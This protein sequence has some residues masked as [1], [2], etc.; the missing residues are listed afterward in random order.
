MM[1]SLGAG[2]LRSPADGCVL[3][4]HP[5]LQH[6]HQLAQALHQRK[7]LKAFWSG[8]PVVDREEPMPWWMPSSYRQRIRRVDIPAS[9]REHPTRFQ[10]ALRATIRF[11]NNTQRGD[12]IHRIFHWFDKWAAGQVAALQP[13][14]VVAY[15]NAAYHTFIAAKAAGALCI[16]DAAAFHHRTVSQQVKS[17]QTPYTAE[18]NRRKDEEIRMAD[19][20]LTCSPLAADSYAANGIDRRRLKPLLLGADPLPALAARTGSARTVPRFIF[21]GPLSRRKAVDLMLTAFQRLHD[22]GVGCELYCVGGVAEPELL[23]AV[24]KTPNAKYFASMPQH[25]LFRLIADADCLVLPSRSDSFGMVVAEAMSCGT[26]ALVST[27]TGAKAIVE[28]FPGSGWIVEPDAAALC[29]QLRRLIENPALLT[30]AR[31]QALEASREFSWERYRKRAG[32][33][34]EE[35]LR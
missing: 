15:E 12:R 30:E 22:E 33:V 35:F 32:S 16:L 27:Q 28:A 23:E 1:T 26:P 8:V 3:V 17:G 10:L 7:L 14:A 19:L 9:L 31:G 11:G 4:T 13:R 5:G 2:T 21:A 6:A 20:I 29:A 24:L 34:L 18:V 25:E